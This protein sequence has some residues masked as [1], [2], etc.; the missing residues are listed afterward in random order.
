MAHAGP[1]AELDERFSSQDAT[2]TAWSDARRHLEE[3]EVYWV[4]TVRPDGRPHVTPLIS[5]WMDDAL[6]F[7]TGPAEQK[8][9]NLSRNPHCILTTGRNALDEGLDLVVEG[10]A[11]QVTD[12]FALQRIAEVYESKYGP[13]W[14]FEV[15]DGA[16][17]HEH[18]GQAVV[19]ELAPV[20]VLGFGKGERFSHTRWRFKR[21]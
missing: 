2:P 12:D 5:V 1:V 8:A 18:G 21:D 6:Y 16:F 13:E 9:R 4:S 15:R 14:H 20:K 17:H 10:D 11:R 3:A 19:Y 7:C